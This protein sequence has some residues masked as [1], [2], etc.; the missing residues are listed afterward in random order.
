[1]SCGVSCL[2]G[3]SASAPAEADPFS[4][5][6]GPL[7]DLAATGNRGGSSKQ[8]TQTTLQVGGACP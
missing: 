8:K 2:P 7:A 1:M 5:L 6:D 4:L 3:A